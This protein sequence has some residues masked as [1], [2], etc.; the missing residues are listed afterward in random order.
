MPKRKQPRDFSTDWEL[1]EMDGKLH[2]QL[3]GAGYLRT[4]DQSSLLPRHDI[5]FHDRECLGGVSHLAHKAQ[6]RCGLHWLRYEKHS[7]RQMIAR[8]LHDSR[9]QDHT[10]ARAVTLYAS[11]EFE[12]IDWAGHSDIADDRAH[13]LTLCQHEPILA[14]ARDKN[15]EAGLAEHVGEV[16]A[17]KR[18]VLDN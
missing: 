4:G 12:T 16:Y 9:Q 6:K 10:D 7:A 14:V 11:R 5:S 17:D 2:V 8:G 1:W 15:M 13:I 3:T 18:L